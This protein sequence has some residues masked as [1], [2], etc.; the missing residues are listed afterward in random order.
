MLPCFP[1]RPQPFTRDNCGIDDLFKC[2]ILED[3]H[4][5]KTD[6]QRAEYLQN[7]LIA[8]ATGGGGEDQE[9]K[10]LRKHFLDNPSTEK[11]IPSFIRTCRDLGQF[12][13]FIKHRFAHYA[14]RRDFIWGEFSGL[15]S[16]LEKGSAPADAAITAQLMDFSA[17]GV[18]DLWNKA[19]ERK[20]SDP[21][22]AITLAK[23]LL[24][25][26]LKHILD[27][28]RI[29][30]SGAADLPE[31]YRLVAKELNLAPDQHTQD[32]F[33]RILGGI[34]SIVN[35]LGTL[36]NRLGDAHGRGKNITKPAARHAEL[37]VNLAGGIA[38]FLIE[39]TKK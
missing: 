25:S 29:E 26:V 15:L 6:L 7:M 3:M 13:S 30:Y 11:L 31:L 19:L 38:L 37:A 32:N 36:R 5:L 39:T 28:R 35:E 34:A 1:S 17:G 22:G 20:S 21:E 23:S 4:E 24:E 12:W 27:E 2:S 9:Y 18:H 10:Q 14:E 16:V 8:L 33:K